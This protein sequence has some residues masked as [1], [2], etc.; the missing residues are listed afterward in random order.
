MCAAD[1][2]GDMSY[3]ILE[4]CAID[5]DKLTPE[6]VISTINKTGKLDLAK[7]K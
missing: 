3:S 6:R 4:T 1:F 2:T 5:G 7:T